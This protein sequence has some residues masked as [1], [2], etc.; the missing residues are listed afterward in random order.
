MFATE[1]RQPVAPG[2]IA[3]DFVLPSVD[4]H[5][6][7]SLSDYRSR[8][9]VFLVLLIGLWCPFCRRNLAQLAA[10]D[11]E[12]KA[13]GVETIGVVATPPEKARLYFQ[14]RP[15]RLCLVTGPDYST[16]RAYGVP[17]LEV[18]PELMDKIATVPVNP[19]GELPE[20]LPIA[21]VAKVLT[22]LDGYQETEADRVEIERHWQQL[23]GQFMIDRE[24]VVRW[25]SIECLKDGYEGIAKFPSADEILHA[26]KMVQTP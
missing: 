5:G 1:L 9:S 15:S 18:T 10:S 3:P 6:T 23:K 17:R 21:E 13:L 16:H 24:G 2:E 7:V 26:A 19:T 11:A 22:R 14:F 20:A 8:N 12:L 25:T 4:G